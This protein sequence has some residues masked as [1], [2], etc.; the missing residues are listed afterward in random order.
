MFNV[1]R[2]ANKNNKQSKQSSDMDTDTAPAFVKTLDA[3]QQDVTQD[4]SSRSVNVR[5]AVRQ[6]ESVDQM[7]RRF[8][9]E[10]MKA[11]V[12]DQ[13]KYNQYFEKPSKRRQREEKER[14]QQIKSY[15]RQSS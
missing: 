1:P 4:D 13:V 3:N 11:K 2:Q 14:I 12:I 5:V 10:V 7:L 9:Y 6:G 8:N 15:E